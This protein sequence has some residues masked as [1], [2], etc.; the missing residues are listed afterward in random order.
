M[1]LRENRSLAIFITLTHLNVAH[2]IV[3]Q[4]AHKQMIRARYM[5]L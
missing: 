5:K 3:Y 4:S 2:F 1:P